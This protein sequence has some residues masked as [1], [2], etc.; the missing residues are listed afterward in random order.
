MPKKTRR[1]KII[2]DSRNKLH[3]PSA[4]V[5]QFKVQ[6]AS[7]KQA[8]DQSEQTAELI[9]IKRDLAKTILLAVG[10]FG[11]EFGLFWFWKS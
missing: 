1:E 6:P 4:H 8:L 5:Y 11:M 7:L 10:A 9:Q 2:A 3:T